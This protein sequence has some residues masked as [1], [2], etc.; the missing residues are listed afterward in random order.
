MPSCLSMHLLHRRIHAIIHCL[1]HI[2]QEQ[3]SY[4]R[5]DAKGH[6]DQIHISQ[7][8]RER[9]FECC[10]SRTNYT[11]R[12]ARDFSDGGWICAGEGAQERAD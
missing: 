3:T 1:P 6:R 7:A 4:T 10:D 2:S 9:I 12:D 5:H 8:V 11:R